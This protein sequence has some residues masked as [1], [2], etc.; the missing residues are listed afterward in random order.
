MSRSAN[1][2]TPKL[3]CGRHGSPTDGINIIIPPP[4]SV[5]SGFAPSDSLSPSRLTLVFRYWRHTAHGDVTV[6]ADARKH[7]EMSALAQQRDRLMHAVKAYKETFDAHENLLKEMRQNVASCVKKR[8][9]VGAVIV[10]TRS[11]WRS[12]QCRCSAFAWQD[13][14]WCRS[15]QIFAGAKDFCPNFPN[16]FVR[17]LPPPP[18]QVVNSFFWDDLQNMV[19]MWFWTGW[20]PIIQNR[21]TLGVIFA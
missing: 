11:V 4:N 14:H 1:C 7:A 3:L 8:D 17:M 19:F 9:K 5:R 15:R 12:R 18:T 16:V 20:A 10:T 13:V 2:A 21:T 6:G